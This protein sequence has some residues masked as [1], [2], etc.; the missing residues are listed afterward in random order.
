MIPHVEETESRLRGPWA[1]RVGVKWG[2]TSNGS[3]V[4]SGD[5]ENVLTLDCGDGSRTL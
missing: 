2:V 5:D 3:E 4:S 1:E